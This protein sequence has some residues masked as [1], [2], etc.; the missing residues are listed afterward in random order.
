ML[1][2][3]EHGDADDGDREVNTEILMKVQ[4]SPEIYCTFRLSLLIFH[5]TNYVNNQPRG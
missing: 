4:I 3:D 1:N 2:H 5:R